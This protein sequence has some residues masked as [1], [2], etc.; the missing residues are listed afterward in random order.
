MNA[1][2]H[3]QTERPKNK[4]QINA[5]YVKLQK[6]IAYSYHASTMLLV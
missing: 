4:N 6:K 3:A 5:H 2:K 1:K